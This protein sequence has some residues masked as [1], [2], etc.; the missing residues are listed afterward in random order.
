MRLYPNSKGS[1]TRTAKALQAA[2]ADMIHV[3]QGF[4]NAAREYERKWD[5]DAGPMNLKGSLDYL[6]HPLYLLHTMKRTP[7][8]KR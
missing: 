8:G 7:R 2:A 4:R 1:A 3:A 5:G 6:C